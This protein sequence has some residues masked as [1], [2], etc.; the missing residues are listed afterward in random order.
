MQANQLA[1][2]GIETVEPT[3]TG[4]PITARASGHGH[5]GSC[6]ERTGSAAEVSRELHLLR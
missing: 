2:R 3:V 6:S 4:Q 5:S 1:H